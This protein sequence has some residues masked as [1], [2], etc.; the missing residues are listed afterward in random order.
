MGEP[1]RVLFVCSRNQW[2]SPTAARIYRADPRLAV[3][4]AG[5]S[6]RSPRTLGVRDLAWAEVVLVM[7][8]EQRRR[9]QQR[10]GRK[11]ELP[12]VHCLD[13]P[14]EY[15]FMDPELVT[16]LRASIEP[17]LEPHLGSR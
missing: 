17:A 10:F 9:L 4:A 8:P 15:G 6:E 16:L 1:L 13:V 7:E 5:L 14:D 3:R 12:A 11:T 2:R